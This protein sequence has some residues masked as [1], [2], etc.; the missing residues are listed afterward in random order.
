VRAAFAFSEFI[1]LSN[2]EPVGMREPV[3][4]GYALSGI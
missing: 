2:L 4:S 3:V 1:I